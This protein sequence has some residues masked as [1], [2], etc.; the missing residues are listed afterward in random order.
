[1]RLTSPLRPASLATAVLLLAGCVSSRGAWGPEA[2]A[3][4]LRRPATSEWLA[5]YLGQVKLGALEA[6]VTREVR[7]GGPVLVVRSAITMA[8]ST[9]RGAAHSTER[10]ERVYEARPGGRLLSF[11]LRATGHQGELS[12]DGRCTPEGCVAQVATPQGRDERRF[13]PVGESIEMA[14][15]ER[16]VAARRAP[17]SGPRLNVRNLAVS[18]VDFAFA[19]TEVIRSGDDDVEV[20]VV[21]DRTSGRQPVRTSFASDGRLLR[22]E[23][24][25]LVG[26]AEPHARAVARQGPLIE[27]G[28]ATRVRVPVELPAAREVP[29]RVTF[30]LL[31]VPTAFRVGDHRQAWRWQ[32]DGSALVTVTARQPEASDPARDAPRGAPIQPADGHLLASTMAVDVSSPAIQAAAREMAGASTGAYQASLAILGA[33]ANRFAVTSTSS[34]RRASDALNATKLNCDERSR[35]F[36]ALARAAGVP[37][38]QVEG[39]LYQR[40]EDGVPALYWRSWVEVRSG[41]EWIAMDPELGQ[42]VADATHLALGKGESSDQIALAGA[43]KALS[44]TVEP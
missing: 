24:G 40:Y 25:H 2:T 27:L 22:L 43:I 38:R 29:G 11:S 17:L 16:L 36:V 44:V 5:L 28:S 19:G 4:D 33:L 1:M 9:G 8:A 12:V 35:L 13:P 39:L 37:A 20:A 21:E 15:A 31:G 32:D 7:G 14:D 10:E 3:L 26:R 34:T 41:A 18:R 42:S 30:E 6:S 23:I